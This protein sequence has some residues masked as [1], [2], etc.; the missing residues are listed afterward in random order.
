M[1][2]KQSTYHMPQFDGKNSP[3]KEFLQDEANGATYIT[4]ATEPGFIKVVLR[5]SCILAVL[6]NRFFFLNFNLY[7]FENHNQE[8]HRDEEGELYGPG[9]AD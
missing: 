3:L 1:T 8:H 7:V 9:I 6:K 2:F 5:G 4:E